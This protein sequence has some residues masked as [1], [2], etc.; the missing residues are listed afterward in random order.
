LSQ[1]PFFIRSAY[2]LRSAL[3]L[4]G[5][6]AM[7]LILLA[8]IGAAH[9]Q[10]RYR[11]PYAG[12]VTNSTITFIGQEFYQ[13]FVALWRDKP[14]VEPFSL[15]VIE[16]PSAQWGSLITIEYSGR[17]MYRAFLSPGRREFIKTAARDASQV[18]YNNVVD[19]EVQRQLFRDPDMARD[20]F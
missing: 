3:A 19:A 5:R 6:V 14:A 17:Q 9:A 11:D 16:R 10:A 7:I 8:G 20:E 15:T 1:R 12:V 13:E 2:F 4:R 18:V